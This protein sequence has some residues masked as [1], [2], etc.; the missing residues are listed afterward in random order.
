MNL[1]IFY[2]ALKAPRVGQTPI[3][4]PV[5]IY[6][7]PETISFGVLLLH[8]LNGSRLDPSLP[9]YKKGKFQ[10]IVRSG[11]FESGYALAE[12][13]MAI[14][15]VV[16]RETHEGAFIHFIQPLHDPVAFPASKGDFVEFSVNYETTYV[17]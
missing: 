5:Y 3:T 4:E 14:F 9:G 7:M 13:V 16:K 2:A 8:N 15:K 12:R 1:N 10:A 11:D 17:E 6:H